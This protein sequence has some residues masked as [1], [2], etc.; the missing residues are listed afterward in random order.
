MQES[1]DERRD[2]HERSRG[3][4]YE[5]PPWCAT[6]RQTGMSGSGT[7]LGRICSTPGFAAGFLLGKFSALCRVFFLGLLRRHFF[8]RALC[9]GLLGIKNVVR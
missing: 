1:M 6:G 5:R 4:G 7:E 8:F 2:I 3:V 9:L